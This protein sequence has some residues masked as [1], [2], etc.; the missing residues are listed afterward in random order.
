MAAVVWLSHGGSLIRTAPEHLVD[1]SPLVTTLF[2]ATNPDAAL[3][4]ASGHRDLRHLRETECADLGDT[5]Q[6]PSGRN[7]SNMFHT[8]HTHQIQMTF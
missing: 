6:D 2:E 1:C 7:S 5:W 8:S 3:P 4:G